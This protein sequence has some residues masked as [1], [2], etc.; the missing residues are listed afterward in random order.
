MRKGKTRY[1]LKIWQSEIGLFGF[2]IEW[3]IGKT[4]L[5]VTNKKPYK[6]VENANAAAKSFAVKYGI[7]IEDLSL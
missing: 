1:C 7:P 3:T 2:I 6:T 5:T 4:F